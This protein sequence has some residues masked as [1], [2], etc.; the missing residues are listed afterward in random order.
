MGKIAHIGDIHLD[1]PLTN[2]KDLKISSER[3]R[4]TTDTFFSSIDKCVEQKV[5]LVL[6]PGDI[7]DSEYINLATCRRIAQKMEQEVALL[8]LSRGQP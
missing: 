2:L 6:L 5:D 4:E 1:S 3:R 8:F 7:F